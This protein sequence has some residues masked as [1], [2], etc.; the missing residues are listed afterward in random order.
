MREKGKPL[1]WLQ[2]EIKTPPFSAAAR[3]RSGFSVATVAS[4]REAVA[5]AFAPYAFHRR[6]VPELRIEMSL[7]ALSIAL[8]VTLS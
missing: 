7:G 1:V 4:R 8:T 6:E 3:I 2:G 5:A